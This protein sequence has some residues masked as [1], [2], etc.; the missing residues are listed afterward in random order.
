M[1]EQL[2]GKKF[3]S[4]QITKV[5]LKGRY[6]M[7][8]VL[9]NCGNIGTTRLISLQNGKSTQCR[10]CG[11]KSC[12]NKL[13]KTLPIGYKKDKW[14]VIDIIQHDVGKTEAHL[15]CECG[16]IKKT[17][18]SYIHS[19]SSMCNKCKSKKQIGIPSKS[20]KGYMDI[21]GV[22]WSALKAGAKSRNYEF[23]ITLEY[24]WNLYLKQN[25]KCNLSGL[26]II[27][28]FFNDNSQTASIDRVDNSKGYIEG[29]VQWVHKDINNMKH[30][31]SQEYFIQLCKEVAKHKQKYKL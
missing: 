26:D 12:A 6:K 28:G 8:E 23:T 11:R 10:K 19:S 20:R 4:R 27:L 18:I 15:Q 17:N 1:E 31:H 29:N 22:Y 7:C 5:F 30:K 24:C 16:Y 21:S 13:K 14:T 9:C 25:K 3:G 2:I